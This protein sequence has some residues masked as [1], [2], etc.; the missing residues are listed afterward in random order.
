MEIFTL[1]IAIASTVYFINQKFSNAVRAIAFKEDEKE[2]DAKFSFIMMII[3]IISWTI[4]I[5]FFKN[6]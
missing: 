3:V 6:S 2:I 1:F 4:Y 5:Y